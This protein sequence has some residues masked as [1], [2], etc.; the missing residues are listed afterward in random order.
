M[1]MQL[2]KHNSLKA[3]TL[4]ELLV[5]VV[6]FSIIIVSS[7]IGAFNYYRTVTF[8]SALQNL[9]SHIQRTRQ[10]AISTVSGQPY[11]V[12]FLPSTYVIF[13]GTTYSAG[14]SSNEVRTLEVGVIV[15]TSYSSDI[16]TFHTPDGR[17]TAAGNVT[18][19]AFGLNK[20]IN[21]NS[22]GFISSIQ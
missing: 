18:I 2:S 22:L 17:T 5:I 10:R 7:A 14:S 16:I 8:D 9:V 15:D 21:I 20:V 11:S 1:N 6:I 12:K 19:A 4:V 3:Y 13:P